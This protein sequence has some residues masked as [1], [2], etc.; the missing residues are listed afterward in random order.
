[1]PEPRYELHHDRLMDL[2]EIR[3][4]EHVGIFNSREEAR[5]Y[6]RDLNEQRKRTLKRLAG[7]A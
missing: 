3:K 2:Y 5:Q 1:M 7:N 4:V 6:M